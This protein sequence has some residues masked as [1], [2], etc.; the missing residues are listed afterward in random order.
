VD[1]VREIMEFYY[2]KGGG[3]LQVESLP[4]V[5]EALCAGKKGENFNFRSFFYHP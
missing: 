1:I 4:G 2:R 3:R 5:M